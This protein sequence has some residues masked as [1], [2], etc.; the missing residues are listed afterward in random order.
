MSTTTVNAS[1]LQSTLRPAT[2]TDDLVNNYVSFCLLTFFMQENF[3]NRLPNL[4]I[5]SIFQAIQSILRAIGIDG[6]FLAYDS[7][8]I[9]NLTYEPIL[10]GEFG[11]ISMHF[12][13][14]QV[15]FLG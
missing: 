4:G 1:T 10:R 7:V 8:K 12:K 11:C 5:H 6:G 2:K 9:T 14:P 13:Q 15:E 3:A